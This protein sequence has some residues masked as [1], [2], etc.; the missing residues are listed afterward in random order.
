MR[1]IKTIM[2][3]DDEKDILEQIKSYLENDEFDI[4]TFEN[5]REALERI[6]MDKMVD[7]MLINTSISPSDKKAFFS[8]KP[9]IKPNIDDNNNF[10]TKPFTK[11]Q[12]IDFIYEKI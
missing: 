2:I 11:Q 4:I 7:L 9:N 5:R 3:I 6:E 8:M 10:L 12:L 1:K